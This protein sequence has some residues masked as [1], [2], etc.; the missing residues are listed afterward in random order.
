M[1]KFTNVLLALFAGL[2]SVGGVASA[3]RYAAETSLTSRYDEAGGTFKGRV[4]SSRLACERNRRVKI[5]HETPQGSE[6]VGRSRS[7]GEGRYTVEVGT[8]NGTY[9]AVAPQRSRMSKGHNHVCSRGE[10]PAVAVN[11]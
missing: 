2:V 6:V 9:R 4:T 10:S 1:R 5:V 11:P 7:D 8:A 3:H